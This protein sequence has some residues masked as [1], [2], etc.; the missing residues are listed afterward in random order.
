MS[1]PPTNRK[2]EALTDAVQDRIILLIQRWK[3]DWGALN[4]SSLERKVNTCLGI[5]CTRQGLMKKPRIEEAFNERL[6]IK[7]GKQPQS[8]SAEVILLEQ[9]IRALESDVETR[10]AKIIELQE[11]VVRYR[12]NAKAMGIQAGRLEAPIAPLVGGQAKV[13]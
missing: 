1:K 2:R 12:A 10:D 6:K 11:I 4:A 5:K 13:S 8:K 9:R 7:G 3:D